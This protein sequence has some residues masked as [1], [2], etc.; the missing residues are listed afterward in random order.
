MMYVHVQINYPKRAKKQQQENTDNLR[1]EIE[2]TSKT[3]LP[4]QRLKMNFRNLTLIKC[5]V[6]EFFFL[7][8][9]LLK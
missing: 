3:K 4:D 5:N 6:N 7:I 1:L 2:H 9:I 8:Y